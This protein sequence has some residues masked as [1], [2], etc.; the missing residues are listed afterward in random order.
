M[1]ITP[2]PENGDKV[3]RLDGTEGVVDTEDWDVEFEE[4][5]EKWRIE[6]RSPESNE[7]DALDDFLVE[8]DYE[9]RVWNEVKE[10]E[11]SG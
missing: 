3:I 5:T 11:D 6:F 7:S 10:P 9:T 8:W 1:R 2:V 4:S